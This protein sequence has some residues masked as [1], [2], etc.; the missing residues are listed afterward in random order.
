[1]TGEE[2]GQQGGQEGGQ[3]GEQPGK[4]GKKGGKK[5]GQQDGQGKG[6]QPEEDKRKYLLAMI[7]R[8]KGLA[9]DR[10]VPIP[11]IQRHG[12]YLTPPREGIDQE[13]KE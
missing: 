8:I 6:G 1:M 2:E 5:G 13:V 11:M 7:C 9:Q 12:R 3:Q 4:G 10:I